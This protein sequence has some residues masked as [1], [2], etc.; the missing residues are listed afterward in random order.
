MSR[1]VVDEAEQFLAVPVMRRRY[2]KKL[3]PPVLHLSWR[4]SQ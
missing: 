4:M 3:C 2:V 1:Q